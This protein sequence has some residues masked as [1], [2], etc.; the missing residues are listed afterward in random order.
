M[1]WSVRCGSD[2]SSIDARCCTRPRPPAAPCRRTH[3][4][5]ATLFKCAY[6]T[7][8]TRTVLCTWH[9]MHSRRTGHVLNRRMSRKKTSGSG[10][11]RLV[12]AHDG[13][14]HRVRVGERAR[15]QLHATQGPRVCTCT[16]VYE[17]STVL[18]KLADKVRGPLAH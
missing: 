11:P 13:G 4:H 12:D 5:T 1:Q 10:V 14:H 6:S 8:N 2:R 18:C 17:N 7:C 3:K 16:V 9:S 15:D